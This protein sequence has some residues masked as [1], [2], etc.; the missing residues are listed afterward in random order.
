MKEEENWAKKVGL[1]KIRKLYWTFIDESIAR[2]MVNSYNHA[3]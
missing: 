1:A 3:N 2:D